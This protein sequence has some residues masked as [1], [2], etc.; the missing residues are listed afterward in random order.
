MV[1]AAVLIYLTVA[2]LCITAALAA[3]PFIQPTTIQTNGVY[4]IKAPA[5]EYVK[6]GGITNLHFHVYNYTSGALITNLTANCTLHVYNQSNNHVVTW[7]KIDY[8]TVRGE[9]SAEKLSFNDT[10]FY[11]YIVQC[12]NQYGNGGAAD[13]SFVVTTTGEFNDYEDLTP[14]AAW[15]LSPL[16]VAALLLAGSF[17]FRD[18]EE[19]KAYRIGLYLLSFVFMLLTFVFGLFA[20]STFYANSELSSV[21]SIVV[22]SVA[23]FLGVVFAY[24]FLYI[25]V[26]ALDYVRRKKNGET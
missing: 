3:P 13:G 20:M 6:Q 19:H 7:L 14:V 11:S 26:W 12:F 9:F 17:L 21:A 2:V 1:R 24:W 23:V 8:D 15:V 4:S 22:W 10:G 5:L 18:D 25:I 16:L